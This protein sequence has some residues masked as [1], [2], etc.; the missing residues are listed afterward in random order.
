MSWPD[1]SMLFQARV[2]CHRVHAF[3]CSSEADFHKFFGF[4]YTVPKKTSENRGL[5]QHRFELASFYSKRST[6]CIWQSRG[7]SMAKLSKWMSSHWVHAWDMAWLNLLPGMGNE[8]LTCLSAEFGERP[9]CS[10]T[11]ISCPLLATLQR[12]L[13]INAMEC[14]VMI[15]CTVKH[16]L[17]WPW[18]KLV[19][20]CFW[21]GIFFRPCSFSWVFLGQVS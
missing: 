15:S 18:M 21:H 19:L 9:W 6:S 13:A 16:D 20:F 10:T 1:V 11:S 7:K 5:S 2:P 8:N 3:S 4:L 17:W 12:S 14:R